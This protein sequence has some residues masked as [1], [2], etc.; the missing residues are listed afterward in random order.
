M[1]NT[2][3]TKRLLLQLKKKFSDLLDDE[4]YYGQNQENDYEP[5][6]LSPRDLTEIG[7]FLIS[8]AKYEA[9]LE[10][11]EARHGTNNKIVGFPAL[12]FEIGDQKG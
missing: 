1:I 6:M 5:T 7:K 4:P 2:L 10:R 8:L 9:D 3:D 12:P 11:E